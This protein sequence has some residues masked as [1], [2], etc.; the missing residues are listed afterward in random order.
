MTSSFSLLAKP[1]GPICNLDCTY[2]YFLSKEALYPH[3]RFRMADETLEEYLRQLLES[4]TGPEVTV[5]W[6]GGEPTLMGLA[7]FRRSLDLV[8]RYRRPGQR[9]AHTIQTNATL[10]DDDWAEFFKEHDFL[11]GVSLDGPQR[12]HDAY[13][14]DKRGRGSFSRVIGG[15]E[16]LRR[17]GVDIN[18]LCTVNAANQH[19]PLEVYRFFRDDLEVEHIQFIPIVERVEEAILP[20]ANGGWRSNRDGKRPLY[21]QKGNRVT[22]RSVDAAAYGTF[23]TTI[24]DE[25]LQHD[26]GRVYV[27]HFDVALASWH[28]VPGG[29]CVFA[30][31]C[32]YALA[33]EHNGDLYSC[34][35]FVEPDHRLGNILDVPLGTLVESRRQEAFGQAKALTLPEYC[36]A[37]EVR[38]AC[39]GGCPKN[40]FIATPDG[41]SGLNYLCPAY[42]VFFN[43]IDTPMRIMDGLLRKGLAPSL[44]TEILR[45]GDRPRLPSEDSQ[46]GARPADT[47]TAR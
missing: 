43:H 16:T 25:W 23:L 30:P 40:R 44:V 6:Q 38:F 33:I 24:F 32:G 34:D 2:C 19:H 27:Q 9:V 3:D 10:L 41:E 20:L 11:V 42:K 26:I 31:T 37:C 15:Y 21:V 22:D 28:D 12:L 8:E 5:A 4:Q 13:R 17:H 14:V 29:L 36:R 39:N 45:S 35:H 18:V 1:T 7:F 47:R 46:P